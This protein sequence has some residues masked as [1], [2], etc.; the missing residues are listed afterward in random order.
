[1]NRMSHSSKETARNTV[2]P[3]AARRA[4]RLQAADNTQKAI[5]F[6]FPGLSSTMATPRHPMQQLVQTMQG[7]D[8]AAQTA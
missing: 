2:E 7:G 4:T 3:H 1:M 5:L 6:Q 8:D